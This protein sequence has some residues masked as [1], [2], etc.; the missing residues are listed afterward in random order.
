MNRLEELKRL[1]AAV[2][3][4]SADWEHWMV[5]QAEFGKAAHEL[6]PGLIACAEAL[7]PL[8]KIPVEEFGKQNQ[9]DYPLVGFNRYV[10]YVRDVLDA[11]AALKMMEAK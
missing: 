10:L 2:H 6:L 3:P 5:A 1:H 9:P 7:E 8:A 11:R 4:A